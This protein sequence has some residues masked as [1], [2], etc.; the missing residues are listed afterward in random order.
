MMDAAFEKQG[1]QKVRPSQGMSDASMNAGFSVLFER[2]KAGDKDAVFKAPDEGWDT[3]TDR[4]RRS[5]S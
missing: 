1:G 5:Q 4:W 3:A 2:A